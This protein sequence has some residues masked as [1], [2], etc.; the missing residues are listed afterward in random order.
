MAWWEVA[1]VIVLIICAVGAWAW[2]GI[3]AVRSIRTNRCT[4]RRWWQAPNG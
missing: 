3:R 1:L 4:G 2:R